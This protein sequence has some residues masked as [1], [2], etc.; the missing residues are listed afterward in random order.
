M[1]VFL[2]SVLT[3]SVVQTY[4]RCVHGRYQPWGSR[5]ERLMNM[6]LVSSTQLRTT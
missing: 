5:P 3:L 2:A 4:I 1:T 6:R